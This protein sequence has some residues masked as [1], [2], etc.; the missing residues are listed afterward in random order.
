MK[1]ASADSIYLA[2]A[3]CATALVALAAVW[4]AAAGQAWLAAYLF[5]TGLPV[6]AL[7]LVLVHGLTGG[8]WGQTLRLALFPMLRT[9]PLLALFLVPVLLGLHKIYPWGVVGRGWLN[10]PFFVARAVVYVL[11]W[12]AIAL[13]VL[14]RVAPDGWLAPSFAWPALILLFGSTSLA[15]FDW[16]MS[17]EPRWTSTIFGL[18]VTAGWALSATAV[19][20]VLASR[21]VPPSR[22]AALDG[23]SR[24]MLALVF[25]WAYLSVVQLIVIWESDLRNEIPWYLRRV[26]SGWQWV[27]L[28]FAVC[29][30]ALP[31]LILVWRPLRQS[32]TAVLIAALS[33]VAAHLGETWWL[34]VP[35]FSRAFSW[36][37][38][39]AVIA[40][41]AAF[42]LVGG[43]GFSS[44]LPLP[45][46]S[47][48]V[49]D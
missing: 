40:M 18:L 38:P 19:A 4:Y 10:P 27:A 17:I 14:R 30:F 24:I 28:G 5:W 25:L 32:R 3:V 29:E 8:A 33:V 7:F 45:A 39:L 11:L 43:R 15:A 6:G 41:G 48:N 31:F 9:T 49:C 36:M 23:P 26:A 20:L 47:G 16:V 13:G 37:D 34:T 2:I 44:C 1:R 21:Y 22:A 35:D 42:L 46:S 12:N